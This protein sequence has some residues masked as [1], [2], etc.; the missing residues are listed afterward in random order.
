MPA[1][2]ALLAALAGSLRPGGR[3]AILSFHSGEDRRVKKSFAAGRRDGIW[4]AIA[5]EVVRAGAAERDSNP[6]ARPHE[7]GPIDESKVIPNNSEYRP[8]MGGMGGM[9]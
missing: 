6:G 9:P 3:V 1:L 4:S 8:V 7:V 2:D 5:E